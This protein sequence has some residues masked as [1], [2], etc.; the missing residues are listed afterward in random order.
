MSVGRF[1]FFLLPPALGL[2]VARRFASDKLLYADV[3][4][5][6]SGLVLMKSMRGPVKPEDVTLI[7]L[8]FLFQL[9]GA[10]KHGIQKRGAIVALLFLTALGI[11]AVLLGG[12]P[13]LVLVAFLLAFCFS[14]LRQKGLGPIRGKNK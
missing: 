4:M 1:L 5:W 12:V 14:F 11:Y 2:L 3:V 8:I 10:T 9:D 7:M 13:Y 6:L